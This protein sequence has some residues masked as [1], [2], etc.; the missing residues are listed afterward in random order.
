MKDFIGGKNLSYSTLRQFIVFTVIIFL[1][2]TPVFYFLTRSYYAEELMDVI[3]GER[4]AQNISSTDL[5]EDIM[6]GVMI[7]YAIIIVLLGLSMVITLKFI[8]HKLWNPFNDT[9]TKMEG[10]NLEQSEIPV[11]EE[12]N[13]TEF[14]RLNKAV[15]QL[16]SRDKTVYKTQKQFTENASHELQTP[17]AIVKCK[18][19][20]LMQEN[21]NS[22]QF[23]LVSEIY[24]IVTKMGRINKDMLML[25]KME[26]S[27][28]AVNKTIELSGFIR[29]RLP[30]YND[31]RG[32]G[33]VIF[34]DKSDGF[35]ITANESLMDSL[36][37]NL[38]INAIRNTVPYGEIII[39]AT[40]DYISIS[41]D[42]KNGPL[43]NTNLFSRFHHTADFQHSNTGLG[44]SIAKAICDYHKWDLAYIFSC[45]KHIFTIHFK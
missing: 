17:L 40:A 26:N 28:F 23:I 42:A 25:A 3:K 18:M 29:K 41:N 43:D 2:A 38:V 13:I 7:Q 44:L 19:D 16:I 45:N 12:S 37:N 22:K 32:R 5:E 9:L 24:G 14:T 35:S 4:I 27:Q 20:L 6:T 15:S 21:L 36:I 8:T 31:L 39:S 1:L 10:F 11:F 34:E 30:V 33:K